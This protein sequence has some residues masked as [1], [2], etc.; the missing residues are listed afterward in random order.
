MG[1]SSAL[2]VRQQFELLLQLLVLVEALSTNGTRF[3]SWIIVVKATC[4]CCEHTD[5]KV[6]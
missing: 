3:D 6:C 4:A 5:S 1:D 2:T